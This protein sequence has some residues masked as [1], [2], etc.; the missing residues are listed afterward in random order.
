[1]I[2]WKSLVTPTVG[3]I[4]GDFTARLQE[5]MP[6]DFLAAA[7]YGSASEGRMRTVS[8][9]NIVYLFKSYKWDA[10]DEVRDFYRQ[11][12]N[13]VEL[14]AMFILAD[15]LVPVASAFPMKYLDIK[16]RHVMISGDD[17]LK[18][19]KIPKARLHEHVEQSL[20]NARIRMVN[21]YLLMS[22]RPEQFQLQVAELASSLRAAAHALVF[23]QDGKLTSP[24]QSLE[25][26]AAQ[27][28]SAARTLVGTLSEIREGRV[29]GVLPP[30]DLEAGVNAL[31]SYMRKENTRLGASAHKSEG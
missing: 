1:L 12:H 8:D 11:V 31:I 14:N 27:A 23:L 13:A 30:R 19:L 5:L 28:D 7:L 25:Q 4:V 16:T 20:L 24:R 2:N 29:Q 26:I 9:V 6:Q 18:D 22:L 17:L 15:E 3:S 21:R 10:L